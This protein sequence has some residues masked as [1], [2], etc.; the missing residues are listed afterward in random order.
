MSE[1]RN[2]TPPPR[3]SSS[4]YTVS[5]LPQPATSSMYTPPPYLPPTSS[6]MY[7]PP[8]ST[9][10]SIYTVS[11]LPPPA[12]EY[13]A[14]PIR[15]GGISGRSVVQVIAPRTNVIAQMLNFDIFI[16]DLD[17]M[18]TLFESNQCSICLENIDDHSGGALVCGHPF[19]NECIKNW[20]RRGNVSCPYCRRQV[21]IQ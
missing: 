20:F 7:T 14:N 3:T 8:P 2:N 4:M 16:Q 5:S 11:S 15:E 13:S 18:L 10:S 12:F 17:M 1:Y 19:H 21:D 6:P 9:S